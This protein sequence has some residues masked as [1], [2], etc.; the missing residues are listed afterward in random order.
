MKNY[1]N[2][3]QHLAEFF[4]EW[5]IL[6][7]KVVGKIKT[8]FMFKYFIFPKNRTVCDMQK[9]KCGTSRRGHKWQY[10]T[11]QGLWILYN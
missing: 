9:K 3:Q 8:H 6:H 4:S 7:T 2:L 5:E 11:T 1:V 10:T